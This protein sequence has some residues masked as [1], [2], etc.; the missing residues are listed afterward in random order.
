MKIEIDELALEPI[1]IA[2]LKYH[3][4]NLAPYYRDI[5]LYDQDPK[6]NKQKV[7]EMKDAFTKVLEY[8][9]VHK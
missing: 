3:R 4:R 9:G 6:V 2:N 7:K 1:I 5:P 8:Y